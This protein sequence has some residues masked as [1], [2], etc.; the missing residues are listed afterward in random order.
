MTDIVP[1][2]EARV[3]IRRIGQVRILNFAWKHV[4]SERI[5][6]IEQ[7]D[8]DKYAPIYT[9]SD[10]SLTKLFGICKQLIR[11]ESPDGIYIISREP[12]A[13]FLVTSM[14]GEPKSRTREFNS[15]PVNRGAALV[16]RF[17]SW[18]APHT[19]E[20]Y[21]VIITGI[22][23]AIDTPTAYDAMSAVAW[24]YGKFDFDYNVEVVEH[25]KE[26]FL[27]KIEE[28]SESLAFEVDKDYLDKAI[29]HAYMSP[30]RTYRMFRETGRVPTLEGYYKAMDTIK[31][32]MSTPATLLHTCYIDFMPPPITSEEAYA[33]L[34]EIERTLVPDVVDVEMKVERCGPNDPLFERLQQQFA[35][36]D[37]V[38]FKYGDLLE[39][40]FTF[41]ECAELAARIRYG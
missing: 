12:V 15:A 3:L 29:R 11:T 4:V 17:R 6:A 35:G 31:L 26:A 10:F 27:Q 21:K 1:F 25:T 5:V 34:G 40:Q 23:R 37:V 28:L 19:R 33:L 30:M 14:K 7:I 22:F 32:Y 18:I 16:P 9:D 20:T 41:G 13:D 24:H 8:D 39:M 36:G 2:P 38:E